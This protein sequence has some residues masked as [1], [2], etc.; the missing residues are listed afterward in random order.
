MKTIRQQPNEQVQP[1]MTHMQDS[2]P[3]AAAGQQSDIANSTQGDIGVATTGVLDAIKKDLTPEALEQFDLDWDAVG[4][5]PCTSLR[6]SAAAALQATPVVW[7]QLLFAA[8]ALQ[9]LCWEKLHTGHWMDV[10]V[11]WRDAY[12]LYTIL[13]VTAKLALAAVSSVDSPPAAAAA[14]GRGGGRSALAE[15]S[16]AGQSAAGQQQGRQH[17]GGLHAAFKA[18]DPST[19]PQLKSQQKQ[20]QLLS[21]ALKQLDL[22]AMMGGLR[23]RPLLNHCITITDHALQQC[24]QLTSTAAGDNSHRTDRQTST[25]AAAE[26][27]QAAGRVAGTDGSDAQAA[28]VDPAEPPKRQRTADCMAAA[29]ATAAGAGSSAGSLE[30]QQQEVPLPPGSLTAASAVVPVELCPSIEQF[31]MKYMLADGG[32]KPV[33][34]RGAMQH[35]PALTK[36]QDTGYLSRVAGRRT[37]PVELGQDYLQEGWGTSLMTF[38][39]FLYKHITPAAGPGVQRGASVRFLQSGLSMRLGHGQMFQ[40]Q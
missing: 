21:G 40:G 2:R 3:P 35:W 31:L 14:G 24:M 27:N 1:E 16:V 37:V 36:W 4:G 10:H 6:A 38:D 18:A 29:A 26:D 20:Q 34:I 23:F 32:P 13:A 11:A 15:A 7:R 12:T 25:T 19:D 28:A 39:D 33:V 9:E 8:D 22:A 17:L 5:S 30:E